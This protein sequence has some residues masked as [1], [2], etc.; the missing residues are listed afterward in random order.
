[1]HARH[2]SP[3]AGR[4]LPTPEIDAEQGRMP[5]P[6]YRL[7]LGGALSLFGTSVGEPLVSAVPG[8]IR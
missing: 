2:Y 6:H 5:R 7:F 8:S 1:M 3:L 4:F